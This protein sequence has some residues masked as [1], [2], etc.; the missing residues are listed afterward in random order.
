MNDGSG[1]EESGVTWA[2]LAGVKPCL[3]MKTPRSNK[4]AAV[5]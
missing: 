5:Y 1:A 3:E 2:T 4:S